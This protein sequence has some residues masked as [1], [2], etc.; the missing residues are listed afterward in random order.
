ME[1]PYLVDMMGELYLFGELHVTDSSLQD[2]SYLVAMMKMDERPNLQN[3]D[4]VDTVVISGQHN[5]LRYRGCI[6]LGTYGSDEIQL[7]T[8]DGHV[9][10]RKT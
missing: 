1:G 8:S 3:G 2:K 5:C 9:R 10:K 7:V 4:F 6:V